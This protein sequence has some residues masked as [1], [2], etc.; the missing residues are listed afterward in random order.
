M[1]IRKKEGR[2]EREREKDLFRKLAIGDDG[3]EGVEGLQEGPEMVL[4]LRLRVQDLDLTFRL[5]LRCK[6]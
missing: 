5:S 6:V 2:K 3:E 1:R 4:V